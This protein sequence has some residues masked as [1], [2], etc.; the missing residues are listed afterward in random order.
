MRSS[1][2]N[3][4]LLSLGSLVVGLLAVELVFRVFGIQGEFHRPRRDELLIP[5]GVADQTVPF[6]F[7][8]QA[9]IRSH[10]DSD[11]RG[12]FDPG[13]SI[14]HRFNS[15]G[16][17]DAEH[18]IDKPPG[19]Y[20]ILGLGDS[21]LFGQGVRADDICLR[22]LE[23][24][25]QAAHPEVRV[26]AINAGLSSLNTVQQ[27]D[28]LLHRGLQY[29]PDLVIVHFVLN[30]VERAEDL[31]LDR[32]KV[33][34]TEAY[35]AIYNRP[36]TLSQFSYLWSWA[37]QRVLRSAAASDYIDECVQSFRDQDEKW[38]QCRDAL[39]DI[40][41]LTRKRDIPL[42]VVVFPFFVEL[43]GEYPFQEIHDTV[44]EFCDRNA[45]AC[46]DLRETFRTYHGP[47]L[48]VHPT[49]QHPNEIA[50]G[51][52]AQAMAEYLQSHPDLFRP[53]A[54]AVTGDGA[55]PPSSP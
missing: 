34:F 5:A 12:Y 40:A 11:P 52:A 28:I 23:A 17:R 32:P 22:Q 48:W 30:D 38:I 16:W 44:R 18:A 14:D 35:V 4:L 54:Q 10:Y 39:A 33:E 47:E 42:L 9:T 36:D 31:F 45:I 50:H 20:R 6:G 29:A 26:E 49:D 21:Y 13:N 46:L 43:N 15:A 8:P 1:L 53:V 19:T 37:R 41:R 55:S 7:V 3:K 2:R 51:R 25:L 24:I 27:R